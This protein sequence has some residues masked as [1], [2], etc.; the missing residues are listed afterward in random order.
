M[1][2]ILSHFWRWSRCD[3]DRLCHRVRH[4][5]TFWATWNS[6]CSRHFRESRLQAFSTWRYICFFRKNATST[7]AF[8]CLHIDAVNAFHQ[9]K[10]RL[11]I[12]LFSRD[13]ARRLRR[14]TRSLIFQESQASSNDIEWQRSDKHVRFLSFRFERSVWNVHMS[15][16]CRSKRN[17]H[18]KMIFR[19]LTPG[20]PFHLARKSSVANRIC[21]WRI[22]CVLRSLKAIWRFLSARFSRRNVHFRQF[23]T[24]LQIRSRMHPRRKHSCTILSCFSTRR[25][26]F[27]S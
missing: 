2:K 19:S 27:R 26:S 23:P 20:D 3:I 18:M 12:R 21:R 22:A 16:A 8:F 7:V 11:S 6:R 14:S 1:T 15:I 17:F 4:V 25:A 10:N 24:R 13:R 9:R 5:R